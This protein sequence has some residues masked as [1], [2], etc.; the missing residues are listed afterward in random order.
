MV[1]LYVVP[2]ET[3]NGRT[4]PKYLS[5]PGKTLPLVNKRWESLSMGVD[6][7]RS[8]CAVDT[9]LAQHTALFAQIDVEHISDLAGER[10]K[11]IAAL[12]EADPARIGQPLVLF[13]IDLRTATTA[14]RDYDHSALVNLVTLA[15]LAKADAEIR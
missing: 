15:R 12:E 7:G 3:V 1:R 9:D 10:G 6:K 13:G 4:S 5:A 2:M 14:T 8:L 11:L